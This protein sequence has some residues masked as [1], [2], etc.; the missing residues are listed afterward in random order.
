MIYLGKLL[1]PLHFRKILFNLQKRFLYFEQKPGI[2]R[3]MPAQKILKTL[4]SKVK[5]IPIVFCGPVL[6]EMTSTCSSPVV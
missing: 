3:Q 1:Q 2:W 6:D 4:N 5:L